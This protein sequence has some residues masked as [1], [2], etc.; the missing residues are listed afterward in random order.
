MATP[1]WVSELVAVMGSAVEVEVGVVLV[2]V[3]KSRLHSSDDSS[4]ASSQGSSHTLHWLPNLRTTD[5]HQSMA[6]SLELEAEAV[7]ESVPELVLESALESALGSAAEGELVLCR[8]RSSGDSFPAYN[9]GSSHTLR[10]LPNLGIA[11]YHRSMAPSWASVVGAEGEVVPVLAW[12]RHHSSD[13]TAP[14]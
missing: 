7:L 12:G 10:W 11:D 1:R 13:D 6:L 3:A 4:P 5:Y 2:Q 9:R 14:A 8:H